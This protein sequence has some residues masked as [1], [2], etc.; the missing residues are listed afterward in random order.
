MGHSAVNETVFPKK[1][2]LI[3]PSGDLALSTKVELF[4]NTVM[5]LYQGS[6]SNLQSLSFIKLLSIVNSLDLGKVI[7]MTLTIT[8]TSYL[9]LKKSRKCS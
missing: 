5:M 7:G 8:S 4:K 9:V 2:L 6:N 1:I 3:V